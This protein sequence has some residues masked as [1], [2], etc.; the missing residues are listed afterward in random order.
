MRSA[1]FDSYVNSVA[2]RNR[3]VKGL[4]ITADIVSTVLILTVLTFSQV[5]KCLIYL[6][7]SGNRRAKR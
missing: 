1:I 5:I 7:E 3:W 6:L 4:K 2:R